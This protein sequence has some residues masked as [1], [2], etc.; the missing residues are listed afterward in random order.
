MLGYWRRAKFVGNTITV[1]NCLQPRPSNWKLAA[2]GIS[3]ATLGS[4]SIASLRLRSSPRMTGPAHDELSHSASSL[5][6]LA[7]VLKLLKG[8]LPETEMKNVWCHSFLGQ[9][10]AHRP[11][12]CDRLRDQVW[13]SMSASLNLSRMAS[14]REFFRQQICEKCRLERARVTSAALIIYQVN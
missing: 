11:G 14:G 4:A 5:L 9:P 10:R 6:C 2:F 7:P 12:T 3:G 13:H 1:T 8:A